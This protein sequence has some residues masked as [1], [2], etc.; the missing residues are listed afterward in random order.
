MQASLAAQPPNLLSHL[1]HSS[2]RKLCPRLSHVGPRRFP[3][4]AFDILVMIA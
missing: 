2:F 4:G 3:I 1:S